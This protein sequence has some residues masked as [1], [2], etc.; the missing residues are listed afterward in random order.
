MSFPWQLIINK[1]GFRLSG[2]IFI[3]S[4]ACTS[5]ITSFGKP[6]E[7]TNSK[8]K[9]IVPVYMKDELLIFMCKNNVVSSVS[10]QWGID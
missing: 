1:E 4:S 3:N 6:D 2:D 8:L 10:W 5:I 9:Y 7:K